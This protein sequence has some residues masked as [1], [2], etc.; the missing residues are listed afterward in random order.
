MGSR[1]KPGKEEEV[2]SESFQQPKK[3]MSSWKILLTPTAQTVSSHERHEVVLT[4]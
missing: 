1:A 2:S 4:I 3:S